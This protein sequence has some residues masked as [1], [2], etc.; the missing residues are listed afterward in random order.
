MNLIR[1]TRGRD[2]TTIYINFE[3]ITS[4]EEDG[5]WTLIIAAGRSHWV[6]ESQENILEVIFSQLNASKH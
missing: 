4:I 2:G 1:L 6:L 3:Q 5:G